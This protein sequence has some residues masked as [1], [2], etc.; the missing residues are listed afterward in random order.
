M[1]ARINGAYALMA[2]DVAL[3]AARWGVPTWGTPHAFQ[4]SKDRMISE[5]V[6]NRRAHL[7]GSQLE[8]NGG[9]VPN[10]ADG[11]TTLR[12]TGQDVSP[13]SESAH[14]EFLELTNEAGHAVDLSGYRRD[15]GVSTTLSQGTVVES[16]GQNFLAANRRAFRSRT[17]PPHGGQELFVVGPFDGALDP[18]ESVFLRDPDGRVRARLALLPLTLLEEPLLASRMRSLVWLG[19]TS[20]V[21]L[22]RRRQGDCGSR[23]NPATGA[24]H[25]APRRSPAIARAR[26]RPWR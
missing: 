7:Y 19:A 15:G 14:E 12:F 20:G 16:G 3:E 2:A 10:A 9:L 13:I 22:A 26:L 1:K 25:A 17:I 21:R 8:V 6:V 24:R 4:Q 5:Y 11:R 18:G 23:L